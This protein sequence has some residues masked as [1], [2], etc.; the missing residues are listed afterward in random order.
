MKRRVRG[1]QKQKKLRDEKT[2]SYAVARVI[3]DQYWH[4]WH[5]WHLIHNQ[6]RLA[7]WQAIHNQQR[8]D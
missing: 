8:E 4:D 7:F 6:Q 1:R 5:D 2:G 3:R